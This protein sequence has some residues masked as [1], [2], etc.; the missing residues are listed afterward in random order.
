VI[1]LRP[2]QEEILNYT[3]GRMAISAVPGSGKTWT[4]SR[5]AAQIVA[6]GVLLDDQEVL[7][8]TLVNSAVE[9]FNQRVSQFI[10]QANLLPRLGYRVRTLHGL[11]HDIVRER[12]GL[13]SLADNFQI[14]DEREADAIR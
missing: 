13:V 11:A 4:L 3:G 6:S 14:V 5:L 7:V 12:P 10:E 8:V 2:A 1:I 9:N